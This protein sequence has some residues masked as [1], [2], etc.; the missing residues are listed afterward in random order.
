MYAVYTMFS[1]TFY[2]SWVT[3]GRSLSSWLLMSKSGSENTEP[4]EA[5]TSNVLRRE[6]V[7]LRIF[8]QVSVNKSDA[9]WFRKII[10]FCSVSERCYLAKCR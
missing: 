1:H 7:G 2:I 6:G 4:S 8:A 3:L 10:C 9:L 5:F